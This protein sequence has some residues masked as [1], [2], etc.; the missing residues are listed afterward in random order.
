MFAWV[1]HFFKTTFYSKLADKVSSRIFVWFQKPT[2]LQAKP[3]WIETKLEEEIWGEDWGK[4]TTLVV[5]VDPS[6]RGTITHTSDMANARTH[7]AC[8]R[9]TNAYRPACPHAHIHKGG[10]RGFRQHLVTVLC[11]RD[12]QTKKTFPFSRRPSAYTRITRTVDF[13][14][15]KPIS[16]RVIQN[17][18]R[19]R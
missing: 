18:Q 10:Q 13:L 4:F 1:F 15:H 5:M 2:N 7:A 11:P 8:E 6:W 3:R 14:S 17:S 19:Y 9:A 16:R 12:P